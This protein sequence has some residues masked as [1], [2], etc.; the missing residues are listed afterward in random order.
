[1][2]NIFSG[3]S[4]RYNSIKQDV[5]DYTSRLEKENSSYDDGDIGDDVAKQKSGKKKNGTDTEGLAGILAKLVGGSSADLSEPM[6]KLVLLGEKEAQGEQLPAYSKDERP[7]YSKEDAHA[8]PPYASVASLAEVKPEPTPAPPMAS[9]KDGKPV[10]GETRPAGDKRSADQII[11]DNPVL[12]NLGNQKDIQQDKLKER[13][14]D[15][16][17]NNKDPKSRADAAWKMA[18]V[19]N[20]IDN[21]KT[22]HGKD[23]K[24]AGNGDITG[25]TKSGDARHGTEAGLLKDFGD[26]GYP[27]I[28]DDQRL[29]TTKDSHV[30][31]DGT[32]KDNFQW[33]VGQAGKVLKYIVPGLG[34]VMVGMGESKGG[35][36]GMIKGGF[37]GVVKTW[38]ADIKGLENALKHGKIS[39][40]Q[41][42]TSM[43]KANVTANLKSDGKDGAAKVLDDLPI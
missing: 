42:A 37:D 43:Y 36:G 16:T 4:D 7:A 34:N 26:K 41:L 40:M 14:G 12:K 31:E 38:K 29:D 20:W 27:A 1:M 23:I 24:E 17:A 39:P 22:A 25:I 9:E 18:H 13:C 8:P 10:E 3:V 19:L 2:N 21:S 33:A 5:S 6:K 32:N 15:W 30:R 28:K 11:N 35:L